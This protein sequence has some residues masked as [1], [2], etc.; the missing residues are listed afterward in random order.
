VT[1]STSTRRGGWTTGARRQPLHQR[2]TRPRRLDPFRRVTLITGG[3]SRGI[4]HPGLH[5]DLS[6]QDNLE[7]AVAAAFTAAMRACPTPTR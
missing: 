6:E 5:A 4:H 7:S 2:P 3:R 1:P